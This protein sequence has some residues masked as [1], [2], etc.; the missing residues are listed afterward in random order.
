[1]AKP[2]STGTPEG[3]S[4]AVAALRSLECIRSRCK[5]VLDLAKADKLQHFKLDESKLGAVVDYVKVR[6]SSC[7]SAFTVANA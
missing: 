7:T 1:M 5:A 6:L 2:A 4:S 3:T